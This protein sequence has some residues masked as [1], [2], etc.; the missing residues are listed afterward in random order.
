MKA[1]S[2]GL[3]NPKKLRTMVVKGRTQG[4]RLRFIPRA[5]ASDLLFSGGLKFVVSCSNLGIIELRIEWGSGQG[6]KVIEDSW[7]RS[8][9]SGKRFCGLPIPNR[10][11]TSIF[12]GWVS[13]HKSPQFMV[14][15]VC[16]AALCYPSTSSNKVVTFSPTNVAA[17]PLILCLPGVN[18]ALMRHQ[19]HWGNAGLIGGLFVCSQ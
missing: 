1:I 16:E 12:Q 7:T 5:G 3:W 8:F 13:A 18:R 15:D 17:I 10:I 2:V 19:Q 14:L 4:S 9:F 6:Q 11:F